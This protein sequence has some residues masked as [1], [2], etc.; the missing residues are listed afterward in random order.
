M[1][2]ERNK[3]NPFQT[4]F[5]TTNPI[6]Q[7]ILNTDTLGDWEPGFEVR[8]GRYIH[9]NRAVEI[10]YW[11]IGD[12]EGSG[13]RL[14]IRAGV[15]GLNT[16]FDFRSLNFA[17]MP[18]N[19][20]FDGAQTHALTRSNEIHNLELNFINFT[21]CDPCSRLQSSFLAGLRY[22]RFTEDWGLGSSDTSPAF[23]VDPANEAFWNIDVENNLYGLQLGGRGSYAFTQKLSAY[24]SPRVG[25]FWNDMSLDYRIGTRHG[26]LG[27]QH[28][29]QR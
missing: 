24:A 29:L 1:Y 17:G 27:R 21:S 5:D 25:A 7:L 2:L 18:V 4:S 16:P 6:G 14:S 23:G 19:D 15:G 20:L 22:F 8:V 3:P 12:F 9:C 11:S 26:R 10:G 13:L 28:Q